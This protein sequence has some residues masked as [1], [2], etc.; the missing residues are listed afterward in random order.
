MKEDY[1]FKIILG[2]VILCLAWAMRNTASRK[3]GWG[4]ECAGEMAQWLKASATN[5]DDLR[6]LQAHNSKF[7]SMGTDTAK[8]WWL[9]WH[10]PLIPVLSQ[11]AE[12]AGSLHTVD[13][14]GLHSEF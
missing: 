9:W 3:G 7:L 11:E 2:D 10:T 13:Q 6:P 12:A 14:P 5:P 8:F 4:R 1:K